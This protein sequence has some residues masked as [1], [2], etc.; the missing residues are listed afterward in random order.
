M[1]KLTKVSIYNFS[2]NAECIAPFHNMLHA[3]DIGV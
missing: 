1:G 2:F 3:N